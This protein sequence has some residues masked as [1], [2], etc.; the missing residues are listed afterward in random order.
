MG[1]ECPACTF[2]N[3]NADFL[4]C[5]C[6]G[7][8]RPSP[9]KPRRL[10]TPGQRRHTRHQAA[11]VQSTDVIDLV[12]EEEAEEQ[13]QQQQQQQ[14][15]SQQQ[16][17]QSTQQQQEQQQEQQEQAQASPSMGASGS[18]ASG[19]VAV[20]RSPLGSS[21]RGWGA[22]TPDDDFQIQLS[23]SLATT[24]RHIQQSGT[25]SVH[26]QARWAEAEAAAEAAA[27]EAEVAAKAVG[28]ERQQQQQQ[29]QQQ[30]P[31]PASGDAGVDIDLTADDWPEP[32][33]WQPKKKK[34]K[35]AKIAVTV[36]ADVAGSHQQPNQQQR[37]QQQQ[38]TQRAGSRQQAEQGSGSSAHTAL[39]DADGTAAAGAGA[40]PA[41]AAEA[42]APPSKKPR[43]A[44]EA[45][46]G[47]AA[48][49]GSAEGWVFR[50]LRAAAGGIAPQAGR[51]AVIDKQAAAAEPSPAQERQLLGAPSG[52]QLP[53]QPSQLLGKRARGGGHPP[54]QPASRLPLPQL[55]SML[56]SSPG[57]QQGQPVQPVNPTLR[58]PP[59]RL[60]SGAPSPASGSP[61]L[62][63]P[64]GSS[65]E[66]LQRSPGAAAAT[67]AAQQGQQQQQQ[68]GIAPD[69][70]QQCVDALYAPVSRCCF[71]W[72]L[73][74][75]KPTGACFAWCACLSMAPLRCPCPAP[76]CLRLP[77]Q[78]SRQSSSNSSLR[79]PQP[80][81]CLPGCSVRGK[82]QT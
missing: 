39:A 11:A 36:A 50:A 79:C 26:K 21:P 58:L 28:A 46:H 76:L 82:A 15:P 6:C 48:G 18:K 7:G 74:V 37:Q 78:R 72:L 75:G 57:A 77:S 4:Q 43:L 20:A 60:S 64:L 47:A 5:E 63:P 45:P 66:S 27:A 32:P 49:G 35:K 13:Q 22:N 10:P 17:Q 54:L 38:A 30:Q 52:P 19:G 1:W 51:Q 80:A 42:A 55:P 3:Q 24:M 41:A 68:R 12:A 81:R 44:P 9:A 16:Q 2:V 14:Q 73:W 31:K 56:L 65:P 40:V 70:W 34:A 29:Q 23:E 69:A 33:A 61:G 53:V 8:E 71:E 67:A 25:G 62:S 59:R